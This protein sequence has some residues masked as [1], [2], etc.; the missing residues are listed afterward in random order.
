[1]APTPPS[2]DSPGSVSGP[3]Q[4]ELLQD[5]IRRNVACI[6]CRDSKVRCRS[7]S[8]AGQPCQRCAKMKL[9]CTKLEVL[10][11]ELKSIKE[12]VNP[13][14]NGETSTSWSP[15][16]PRTNNSIFP[17]QPPTPAAI[18]PPRTSLPDLRDLPLTN[19]TQPP[20]PYEKTGPTK[21]RLLGG[22]LISGEDIDWYFNRYLEC[23]HPYVPVLRKRDPDE[24]YAA[25]PTLFWTVLYVASRRYARQDHIY[26]T[27]VDTLGKDIYALVASPN[28][29]LEPIHAILLLSAWPFPT[30]RFVTDPSTT[31]ISMA[32]SAC[33]L[34]GLHN[35]RGSHPEFCIGGRQHIQSTDLEAS[36]TWISCCI[37]AQR[38]ATYSGIPPPFLL[39]N[40]AQ[41][42]KVVEDTLSSELMTL[43]ELEKFSNR[44]HIA[45]A[46]QI[47]AH[48]GVFEST[49]CSWED[50][51]EVLKPL[52]TRVDTGMDQMYS[53][54]SFPT[55]LTTLQ[56][57]P[58]SS[59]SL[60]N[61]RFNPT[62]ST[63]HPPPLPPRSFRLS[64]PTLPPA[65][66]SPPPSTS[67]I[68]ASSS[69]TGRTGR[70][71]SSSTPP[72]SS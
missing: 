43:F 26:T 68:P 51:F 72:A 36:T 31:L 65:K 19:A 62:S 40:D 52:V 28:L 66:S 12:A 49:V 11:Q 46:G 50:E 61:S 44:L 34:L 58:G 53:S 63:L 64:A 10:E 25:C 39:H 41:C 22:Q 54:L 59:S 2:G 27:L 60:P 48:D 16:T 47:A 38:I 55:I 29:D 7:G 30:V 1:M 57:V 24:C 70:T 37:L 56:N 71:A 6:S 21:A 69:R 33:M 35:G 8:V 5:R 32:V 67:K 4:P 45:M 9:T 42:K 14:V 13:R 18:L 17:P 20:A 15:P 3:G 23:F